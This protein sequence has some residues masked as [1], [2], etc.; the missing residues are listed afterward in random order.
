VRIGLAISDG[1]GIT[2]QPL[3]VVANRDHEAALKEMERVI[4]DREVTHIVVGLPIQMN[5]TEGPA[6]AEVRAFAE[7]L[8]LRLK[9]P[10][11][12]WDERLS[13]AQAERAMLDAD[14]SR[15]S[16]K[17]RRDK[18]AAQIFLQSYLDAHRSTNP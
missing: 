10:I 3:A 17:V 15:A 5:G 16:R 8:T 4:A 2:A 7:V 14:L 12:F 13:T 6:A 11:E 9:L 18:V 1:L